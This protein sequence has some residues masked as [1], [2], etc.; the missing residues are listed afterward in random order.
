M[1]G[2]TRAARVDAVRRGDYFP[3]HDFQ[4]DLDAVRRLRR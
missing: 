2:V 1:T 4:L 3:L